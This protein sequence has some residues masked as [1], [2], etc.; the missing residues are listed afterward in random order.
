V[1]KNVYPNI[2]RTSSS[3]NILARK[4][5]QNHYDITNG[6]DTQNHANTPHA[7]VY[8]VTRVQGLGA[9]SCFNESPLLRHRSSAAIDRRKVDAQSL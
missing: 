9:P 7:V 5:S 1:F 6:F 8:G 3:T 4:L 2:Q